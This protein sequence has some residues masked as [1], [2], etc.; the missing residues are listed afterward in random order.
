MKPFT[1]ELSQETATGL[2]TLAAELNAAKPAPVMRYTPAIL[3]IILIESSLSRYQRQPNPGTDALRRV[4][5]IAPP[6]TF[7][8]RIATQD[9]QS[10]R[11]QAASSS[12]P[13]ISSISS[14]ASKPQS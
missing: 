2:E 8:Q 10:I 11:S 9:M 1:I 6:E 4:P 7:A 3:A 14:I 13:S 5:D 12:I